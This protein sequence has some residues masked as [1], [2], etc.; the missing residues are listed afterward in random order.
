MPGAPSEM[1]PPVDGLDLLV[2]GREF[3]LVRS[4]DRREERVRVG[5]G[6]A[7]VRLLL[8][9][10]PTGP[11]P[12]ALPMALGMVLGV[13]GVLIGTSMLRLPSGLGLT[14]GAAVLIVGGVAIALMFPKRAYR[15][16]DDLPGGRDRPPLMVLAERGGERTWYTL[17]DEAGRTFGDITR[18]LGAWR[19]R[20]YE[21]INPPEASDILEDLTPE[22]QRA[23]ASLTGLAARLYAW[24]VSL[25]ED[26]PD[27]RRP[28]PELS[29][30]IGRAYL[31]TAALVGGLVSG[32]LGLAMAL[33]GP[34][35]RVEFRRAGEV[36]A[37]GH[38]L[39]KGSAMRLEVRPGFDVPGPE[40]AWLDRRHL[41]AM[42]VLALSFEGDR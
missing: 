31:N 19:V 21:P 41:L 5:I 35:K 38:R 23:A 9:V 32:P 17:R 2:D 27:S 36:V 10:R 7:T 20:G 28:V 34:W 12:Y 16:H 3:L 42:A 37:I 39:D 26:V 30:T 1:V 33:H 4:R 14:L 15:F 24:G 25:G 11:G 8:A 40:G 13:A 29:V 18:R 22:Q 6:D